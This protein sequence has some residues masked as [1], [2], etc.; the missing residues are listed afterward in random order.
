MKEV[1]HCAWRSNP[2][3]GPIDGSSHDPRRSRAPPT[4]MQSAPMGGA[5]DK[6]GTPPAVSFAVRDI[7]PKRTI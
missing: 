1:M 6:E 5:L 4:P 3:C 7:E 2:A